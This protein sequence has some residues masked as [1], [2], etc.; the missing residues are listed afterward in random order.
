[1]PPRRR[2]SSGY[3]GVRTRPS[4]VFYVEIRSGETRLTLDTFDTAEQAAR[5][6]DA[7]AW[8]LR[9][10]HRKV[11]FLEVATRERAQELAPPPRVITNEDRRENMRRERGPSI[12]E[13]NEG[14][15]V[16]WRQHFSED[17]V[18]ER[19]FY[20]QSAERTAK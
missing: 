18:N 20:A 8:R 12:A 17:V 2:K 3:R 7:A 16:V 15:M 14:A 9:R 4:D 1:M 5:V 19:E 13:M 6:Y 10:P 11:N